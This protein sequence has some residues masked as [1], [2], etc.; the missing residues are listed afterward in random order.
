MPF[1]VLHSKSPN[2]PLRLTADKRICLLKTFSDHH[3]NVKP[4]KDLQIC[5]IKVFA[6]I[7]RGVFRASK[8]VGLLTE[9]FTK[10]LHSAQFV[11]GQ[12][13]RHRGVI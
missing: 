8:K 9:I 11:R 7:S 4:C 13:S 2:W 6:E 5:Q 1:F 12:H 3:K 10:N